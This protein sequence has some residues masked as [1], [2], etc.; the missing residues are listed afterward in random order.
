[1]HS[2]FT[3]N[4]AIWLLYLLVNFSFVLLAYK[5]WGKIGVMAFT[6]ISIILANIQV[7][8][9]V[10]LFGVETT[11]G[12]IAYSSIFLISDIIT[13]NYGRKEAQKVVGLGFLTMI[14]TTLV[15][16]IV[17]LLNPSVNDMNQIHIKALFTPFIRLT[18][19]SLTA[20]VISSNCDIYL[21]QF[22]KKMLPSFKNL[23]I[24]NNASTLISQVIDNV[25]F[26]LIA[27]YGVYDN[28]TV[29]SIMFSTYFLKIITS[30]CDTPFVYI[31][32]YWKNK[33][34]IKE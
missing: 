11:L 16:N 23:W 26:T 18:V 20:Y 6:P 33:C 27:F 8:K 10:V 24:R 25:I 9:L 17:I 3:V 29:I 34:M 28:S 5:L 21:Y 7:S 32:T 31:A 12:N 22:I 30:L 15:M 13:E 2:I 4:E 1:M 19:A 14:F